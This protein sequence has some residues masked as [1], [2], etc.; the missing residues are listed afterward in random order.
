[1]CPTVSFGTRLFIF[2]SFYKQK[3]QSHFAEDYSAVTKNVHAKYI[4]NC[5]KKINSA[6][7]VYFIIQTKDDFHTKGN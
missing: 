1:M 7:L 2:F 4:F 5:E 3:T 6:N